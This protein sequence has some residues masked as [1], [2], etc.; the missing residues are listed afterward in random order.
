[1]APLSIPKMG[2]EG[3]A[4]KWKQWIELWRRLCSLS[5]EL[6][7][8]DGPEVNGNQEIIQNLISTIKAGDPIFCEGLCRD[9]LTSHGNYCLTVQCLSNL[10]SNQ[11]NN[12]AF[13]LYIYEDL[14][15]W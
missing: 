7:D 11:V 12:Y 1:M 8:G 5:N 13:V 9:I 14:P 6:V 4:H 2:T 3:E 15:V 10:C